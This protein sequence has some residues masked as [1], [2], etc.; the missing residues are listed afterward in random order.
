MAEL[1]K[2][3]EN[4]F[5][6]VNIA[7]VNELAIHA[8]ALGIDIWEVSKRPARTVRV[9]AVLARPR[10]RWPLP[11]DRPVIPVVANRTPARR[12]HASS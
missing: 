1:T 5:R 9:H 4:T 6:H 12:R 3:L 8:C 11:A 10:R 7:L 2:L